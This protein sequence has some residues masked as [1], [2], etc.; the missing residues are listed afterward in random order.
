MKGAGEKE[1]NFISSRPRKM[2]NFFKIVRYKILLEHGHTVE[3]ERRR[4]YLS[5]YIYPYILY[6][7][8][9]IDTDFG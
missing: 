7:L 3:D 6:M 4:M 2:V 5:T 1:Q 8:F 9:G